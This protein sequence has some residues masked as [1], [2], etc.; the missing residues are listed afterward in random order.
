MEAIRTHDRMSLVEKGH[1]RRL[2]DSH[3]EEE[4]VVHSIPRGLLKIIESM[5]ETESAKNGSD[6][7]FD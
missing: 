4:L 7:C 6:E 5:V 3:A 2:L 1:I